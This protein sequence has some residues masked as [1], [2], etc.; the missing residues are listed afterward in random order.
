[1]H[2]IQ[3]DC[4]A[5]QAL[6]QTGLTALGIGVSRGNE[7]TKVSVAGLRRRNGIVPVEAED[8]WH[9]G[10][11]GKSV[12]AVLIATLFE[13]DFPLL[14][15]LV[16]DLIPELDIHEAWH[17][18]TLYHLLTSTSGL[19]SNFPISFLWS[20]EE[21]PQKLIELRQEWIAKAMAKP[22]KTKPGTKFQYSNLGYT[23]LGF[24]AE[25]YTGQ[26]FQEL[27]TDRVLKP[28]GLNSAGFSAPKGAHEDEEPMGHRVLLGYRQTFNPFD[29][30]SDLPALIAPAGR[31][32]MSLADLLK[33]G[34]SHLEGH[35]RTEP[36]L[37]KATWNLLHRPYLD[38]YG[39]GWM[40]IDKNQGNGEMIWHNGSNAMWYTLLI[41][42]PKADTVLAFVTNDGAVKRAEEKFFEISREI[43]NDC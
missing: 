1:M 37:K 17:Q 38:N 11:V 15:C 33:Y 2:K 7:A 6:E 4:L 9:I 3:I 5:E 29:R 20:K 26:P 12:T 18:C 30:I 35:E 23:V 32:H 41:F 34:R 14:D 21:D 39:C 31:L 25:K 27:V 13:D 16:K 22:P 40:A 8:H 19:P 10:S 43:L 24:I 28:L 42:V 36:L